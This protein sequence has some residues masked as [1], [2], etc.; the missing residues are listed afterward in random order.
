MYRTLLLAAGLACAAL[1]GATPASAQIVFTL[2]NV[3]LGVTVN[4][5]TFSAGSLTGTFTTS[6]STL[7]NTTT[8]LSWNIVAPAT[9]LINGH[10]FAGFN[11]TPADSTAY[12]NVGTSGLLT[13]FELDA[14]PSATTATAAEALRFYF[15]TNLSPTGA[16]NLTTAAG[17]PAIAASYENEQTSGGNRLVQTGSVAAVPEPSAWVLGFLATAWFA[18]LCLRSRTARA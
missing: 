10:A 18:A 1:L 5:T 3:S 14:P 12:Y 6:S 7:T 17:L 2:N 4:S 13:G 16:V 15:A 8:L 9:G 11:F